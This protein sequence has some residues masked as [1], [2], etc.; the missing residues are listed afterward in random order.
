MGQGYPRVL[1]RRICKNKFSQISL[2]INYNNHTPKLT[3]M[4]FKIFWE[5]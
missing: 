3:K 5:F 2:T 4:G 1:G